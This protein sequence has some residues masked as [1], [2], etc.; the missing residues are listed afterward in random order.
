MGLFGAIGRETKGAMRS[1]H[2]DL[3][4]SRRFRKIG[5]IAVVTVAGGVLATG[6]LLR[7]PV[8]GLMGLGEDGEGADIIEGWF[9]IGAETAE[10]DPESITVSPDG[11]A[12]EA[13]APDAGESSEEAQPQGRT[14]GTSPAGSPGLSPGLVPIGGETTS[15][16]GETEGGTTPPQ[17][18][19]GEPTDS[20]SDLPS[21]GGPT[22]GE[23]TEDPTSDDPSED[24]SASE[25]VTTLP[26]QV[27]KGASAA[28]EPRKAPIGS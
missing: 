1:L 11:P 16:P 17:E 19:T 20:P 25:S 10:Q 2:Y 23:P 24:P 8:P 3:R 22:T 28:P 6:A 9:G 14:R 4:Q 18:T 15:G 21:T 7:E 13:A 27:S 5:A 26:E 12:G